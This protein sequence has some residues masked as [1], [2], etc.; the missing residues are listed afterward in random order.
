[1][2][3]TRLHNITQVA[4]SVYLLILCDLVV[5]RLSDSEGYEIVIEALGKCQEWVQ[6]KNIE[7]DQLYFYLENIDENDIMTYMQMRHICQRP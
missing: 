4:K 7:A 6:I 3:M 5:D 2:Q 1:M